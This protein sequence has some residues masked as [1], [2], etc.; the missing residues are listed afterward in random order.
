[1][2]GSPEQAP[3]PPGCGCRPFWDITVFILI[4]FILWMERDRIAPAASEL[5]SEIAPLLGGIV[6]T[7]EPAVNPPTATID[8]PLAPAAIG[9]ITPTAAL[10]RTPAPTITAT[11]T[12][13]A[14]TD[15][16][17]LSDFRNG[18]WLEQNDPNLASAISGLFWAQDGVNIAEYKAIQGVIYVA[19]GSRDLARS[20]VARNWVQDGIDDTEADLIYSFAF[21]AREDPNSAE[22][23]F[24]MPFLK[25]I[26]PPDIPALESMTRLAISQPEIFSGVMSHPALDDGISDQLTP[27]IATL[28]GVAQTN[29]SL[30]HDLLDPDN[31]EIEWRTVTLPL[32]GDV[33][34]S[35]VRTGPGAARS[36][37]LLEQAVRGAE[38]HTDAPLPT[39]HVG[40]LF[41]NAVQGT[42]AGTNFGTHIA[43]R[44][45]FDVEDDTGPA[46][47]FGLGI[48]HEVAH[49]YWSGNADWIDEGAAEFMAAT[50][51]AARTGRALVVGRR[52]CVYADSI[53]ELESLE[54]ERGEAEFECNYSL[55]ARLFMDL[56]RT[57]GAERFR[58][59]FRA[60][61]L[62]ST[63]EDDA[64][65]FRGTSLGIGHVKEA[66]R[67]VDGAE[68]VV[69]ARWYDG[70]EPYDL[71]RVD[72]SQVDPGLPSINGRV[73]EAYLT[74]GENGPRVSSFS[75]QGTGDWLVLNLEYSY[76]LSGGPYEMPLEIVEYYQDGFALRRQ[77]GA[78]S[79]EPRSIGGRTRLLVGIGP[80]QTW[81][82]G[83]YAVLVYAGGRKVAAVYYE[84]T[85]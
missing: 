35:I 55:G 74:A 5:R 60:L 8:S 70:T 51:E 76:R 11:Q 32:S 64:G 56:Y 50:I 77:S 57:L 24:H 68:R 48:A 6:V 41:E 38:D 14:T 16:F 66:F 4:A 39:K 63:M 36:M 53:S 42:S 27:I 73:D 40:L 7:A 13:S 12:S 59:G 65:G 49:Y 75:K 83:H 1:M 20:L 47:Y 2:A 82:P 61:Y 52:P 30:A 25:S 21:L 3:K 37:D 33:V 72:R 15:P 78:L 17:I 34:L 54:I 81:V 69:F 84:V 62:A 80:S 46:A 18:L 22:Q 85:P 44:P 19:V 9:S 71:S 28:N 67:T 43:I 58:Q 10:A 79:A 23:I 29:P 31:V 45:E 26:E